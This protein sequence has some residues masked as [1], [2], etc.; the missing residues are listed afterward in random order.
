MQHNFIMFV[1]DGVVQVVGRI[2]DFSRIIQAMEAVLPDLRTKQK[3]F[4]LSKISLDEL[5]QELDRRSDE[6]VKRRPATSRK[7][8]DTH[9]VPG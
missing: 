8:D 1:D 5:K 9:G 6:E 7:H 3:E 4:L 2:E